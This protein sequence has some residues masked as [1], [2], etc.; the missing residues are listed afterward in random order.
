M[1]R[2]S[3]SRVSHLAH[4]IIQ[5]LSET[6]LVEFGDRGKSLRLTKSYLEQFFSEDDRLDDVVRHKIDSLSR[7][8]QVGSREWEILYRKYTEEEVKKRRP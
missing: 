8:V 5:E 7:G 4:L 3:E 6:N 2:F 1:S